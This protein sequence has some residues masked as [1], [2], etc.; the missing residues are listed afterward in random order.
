MDKISQQKANVFLLGACANYELR[1]LKHATIN[2]EVG[3]DM[4]LAYTYSDWAGSGQERF[5]RLFNLQ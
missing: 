5:G 3:I 2:I 4:G 1:L